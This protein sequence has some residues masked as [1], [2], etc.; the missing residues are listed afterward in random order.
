MILIIDNKD[1]GYEFAFNEKE[2]DSIQGLIDVFL[3]AHDT[4]TWEMASLILVRIGQ[5]LY[6]IKNI[7]GNLAG[8][9]LL[10]D[11]HKLL[12]IHLNI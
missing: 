7:Y 2:Q 3:S 9:I 4:K 10:S 12:H 11:I 8:N 5:F 6:V 1:L